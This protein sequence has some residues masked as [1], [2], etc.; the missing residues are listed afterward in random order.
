MS[1]SPD[2]IRVLD[3]IRDEWD[4][5][6]TDIKLAEQVCKDIIVPAVKE[7]RYAGRRLVDLVQKIS[8]EP[9]SGE[10]PKLLADVEFDCHRARHDA[11]D[12]ASAKI[13]IQLDIMAEKLGYDVILSVAPEFRDIS[14]KVLAIRERVLNTRGENRK[15]RVKIYAVVSATN[16]KDLVEAYEL[17]KTSEP[18]MVK[19][20]KLGRRR[21]FYGRWG[22]W[23]GAAGLLIGAVSIYLIFFPPHSDTTTAP[24]PTSIV[25]PAPAKHG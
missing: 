24:T 15:D 9:T 2:Q 11:I 18:I 7:L 10:I 23:V 14:L 5:A 22:F 1:L 19:L 16:F 6:E 3:T 20:A 4:S 17:L 21:D 25:A 13:A 8:N 12:A